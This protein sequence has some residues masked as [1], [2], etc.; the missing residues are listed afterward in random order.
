MKT[1]LFT[2]T[3]KENKF[4]GTNL[5]IQVQIMYTE[6]YKTLLREVKEY[7]NKWRDSSCS[8]GQYY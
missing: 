2:I 6:N 3:L 7:L 8:W 5:T 1:I 4:L